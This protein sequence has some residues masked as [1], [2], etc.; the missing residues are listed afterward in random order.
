MPEEY[1]ALAMELMILFK[2]FTW[3]AAGRPRLAED[4]WLASVA[5]PACDFL[6]IISGA[7]TVFFGG[8]THEQMQI[9]LRRTTANFL[10]QGPWYS[11]RPRTY[12]LNTHFWGP[13]RAQPRRSKCPICEVSG[14]KN[15]ALNCCLDPAL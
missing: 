3:T 6:S 9:S 5:R 13:E 10:L 14:S 2:D 15:H 4:S 7:C 11:P 8:R 12:G 1:T